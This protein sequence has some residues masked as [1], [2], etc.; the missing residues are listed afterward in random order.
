MFQLTLL[1]CTGMT[2]LMALN[3]SSVIPVYLV[4][5]KSVQVR[6]QVGLQ[7]TVAIK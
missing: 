5:E 4:M 6:V 7:A 3:V 2:R 1:R